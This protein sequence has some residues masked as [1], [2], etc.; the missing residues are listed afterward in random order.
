MRISNNRRGAMLPLIAVGLVIFTV[1]MVFSVDIARMHLVRAE[2]RLATD[3]AARAGAEAFSREQNRNAAISAA[4]R[5]GGENFVGGQALSLSGSDILLGSASPSGGGKFSF[6][7]GRNP[8]NSVQVSS[9]PW[10]RQ[11]ILGRHVRTQ[12]ISPDHGC[13]RDAFR[14]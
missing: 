10:K 8:T 2:L 13:C 9:D 11:V 3:A 7:A 12:F 1:V 14:S 5:I 6:N 4:V